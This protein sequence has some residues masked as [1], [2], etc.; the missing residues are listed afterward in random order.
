M[1]INLTAAE[2]FFK[3]AGDDAGAYNGIGVIY[4]NKKDYVTARYWFEKGIEM[5]SPDS[6]FNLGTLYIHGLG[7]LEKNATKGF[8]LYEEASRAGHWRAPLELGKMHLHGNGTPVN[9]TRAAR[10]FRI[11]Y[12]ERSGWSDDLEDA[13]DILD[14]VDENRKRLKNIPPDPFGALLSYSLYAEQGSEIAIQNVA[15][16]LRKNLTGIS[17]P[18]RFEIAADL[19][20]R[21]ARSPGFS[22]E[23]NI[24]LG[25]LL[26]RKQIAAT[27]QDFATSDDEERA[28]VE[29][30][31]KST[32]FKTLHEGDKK[33][34]S[35]EEMNYKAAVARY[36]RAS[37]GEL[38]LPEAYHAL[39]WA[40]FT[41]KGTSSKNRTA[42]LENL[43]RAIELSRFD[44]EAFPSLL[45]YAF[46]KMKS[47]L[48]LLCFD[49]FLF[50]SEDAFKKRPISE[51]Q[52]FENLF[53]EFANKPMLRGIVTMIL[54][55]AIP[56][57]LLRILRRNS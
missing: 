39:A 23:A 16:M 5:N 54:A 6:F 15:W 30:D 26:W 13:L 27:Q 14:G 18:N 10:L 56:A 49:R 43:D 37:F 4:Y 3:K 31:L 34:S 42:V 52:V 29:D 48:S 12:D 32:V 36:R 40:Y 11:F 28:L 51:D 19:L 35:N 7:D 1:P 50:Y 25:D 45:F 38:Q 22:P 17:I 46:V 44:Y 21:L 47:W 33:E 9:C 20:R 2:I 53:N 41:G 24:D 8:K 57:I 55:I